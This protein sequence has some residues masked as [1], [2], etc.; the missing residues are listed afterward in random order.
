MV[1]LRTYLRPFFPPH[2]YA[3]P[4]PHVLAGRGWVEKLSYLIPK[5]RVMIGQASGSH[6]SYVEGTSLG[7][8]WS[9]RINRLVKARGEI[10]YTA[11]LTHEATSNRA[12]KMHLWL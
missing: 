9:Y 8:G 5:E 12:K 2:R 4:G 10:A 1:A 11:V 3:P 7:G 6:A